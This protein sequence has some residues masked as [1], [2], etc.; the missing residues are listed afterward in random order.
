MEREKNR[1]EE[2]LMIGDNPFH[3]IQPALDL[4]MQALHFQGDFNQIYDFMTGNN[5]LNCEKF[6]NL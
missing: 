6:K 4:G 5:I 2:M 1:P 3:D